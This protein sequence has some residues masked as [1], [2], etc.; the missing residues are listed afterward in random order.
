M[1]LPISQKPFSPCF[2]CFGVHLFCFFY[3]T[4]SLWILSGYGRRLFSINSLFKFQTLC[5]TTTT[6]V[7]LHFTIAPFFCTCGPKSTWLHILCYFRTAQRK[8]HHVF[9][10]LTQRVNDNHT[11]C[12]YATHYYWTIT[13]WCPVIS[14]FNCLIYLFT[15]LNPV[16]NQTTITTVIPGPSSMLSISPVILPLQLFITFMMS[17]KM[18]R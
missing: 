10:S 8:C 18:N 16:Y 14:R 1:C 3:S 11:F 6:T 7:T 4:F 12:E 9:Y 5:T 2:L 17:S 15:F 13:F